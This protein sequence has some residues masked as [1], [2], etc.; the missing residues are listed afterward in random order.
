MIIL[1]ILLAFFVGSFFDKQERSG[2]VLRIIVV[3]GLLV[4]TFGRID[5][6]KHLSEYS[7]KREM[8]T[9]SLEQAEDKESITLI[10]TVYGDDIKEINNAIEVSRK[11]RNNLLW[12]IWHEPRIGDLEP[13]VMEDYIK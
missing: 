5:E 6:T 11:Y 13:I 12:N 8:I 10:V 3:A 2:A 7:E 9:S 4:L 1:V